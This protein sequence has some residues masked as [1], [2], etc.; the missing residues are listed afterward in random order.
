MEF[1]KLNHGFSSL[2]PCLIYS[3]FLNPTFS[4]LIC[5]DSYSNS[6]ILKAEIKKIKCSSRLNVKKRKE[7]LVFYSITN[8]NDIYGFD[9]RFDEFIQQE[10]FTIQFKR[11]AQAIWWK[12]RK[13]SFSIDYS[14]MLTVASIVSI[15]Y[16]KRV[17]KRVWS[18]I[19][20]KKSCSMKQE[21]KKVKDVRETI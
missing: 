16:K 14:S 21:E 12:R 18:K 9:F 15:E 17:K 20:G 7:N 11:N 19:N 6:L 4:A 13:N 3:L 2:P 8:T 1:N 10:M 5:F